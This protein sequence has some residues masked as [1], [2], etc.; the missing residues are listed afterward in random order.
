MLLDKTTVMLYTI[1]IPVYER[2]RMKRGK[3]KSVSWRFPETHIAAL[4]ELIEKGVSDHT[5]DKTQ[6]AVLCKALEEL[7][8]ITYGDSRPFPQP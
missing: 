8:R 1:R 3:T 7:W 2:T 5:G 4:D 6:I